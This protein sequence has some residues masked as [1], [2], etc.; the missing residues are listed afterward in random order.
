MT[1]GLDD[2]A[3]VKLLFNELDGGM[4]MVM[5]WASMSMPSHRMSWVFSTPSGMPS[6]SKSALVVSKLVVHFSWS[7]ATTI[8]SSRYIVANIP[9]QRM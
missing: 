4:A 3:I 7:G 5:S 8:K 2:S 6:V 9:C 1:G